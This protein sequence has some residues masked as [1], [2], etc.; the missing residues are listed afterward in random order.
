MEVTFMKYVDIDK[1]YQNLPLEK[2]PWNSETP[3][4][5][6]V[7]LVESGK[8]QPCKTI[9]SVAAPATMRYTSQARD[10]R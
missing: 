4:D 7:E 1:I 3:P 8:V 9:I 10:L 6:L 2:I 5:E